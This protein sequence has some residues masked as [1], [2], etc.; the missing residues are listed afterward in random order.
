MRKQKKHKLLIYAHYYAPD[1]ASTGQLL[2]DMAEGMLDVFDVT[3]ICTVPSYGGKIAP[4]YKGEKYYKEKIN[5]VKVIRI[6]VPILLILLTSFDFAKVVFGDNKD[7]LNKAKNNF[8][9]RA[10]AVLIIFF[11]PYIIGLI[12]DLV[13]EA[14]VK[15]C[16]EEMKNL[17]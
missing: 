5:G 3:V 15:S 7:G 11:A 13:N 12:L 17:S 10:V 4:E 2:Q 14:S 8:L 1:V 9:K 16:V 6:A